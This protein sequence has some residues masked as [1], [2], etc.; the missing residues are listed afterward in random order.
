MTRHSEIMICDFDAGMELVT[1]SEIIPHEPREFPLHSGLVNLFRHALLPQSPPSVPLELPPGW[2][3]SVRSDRSSSFEALNSGMWHNRPP[4]ESRVKI[5]YSR[6][7]SFFD[8][9][10]SSLVEAR[11]GK[12]KDQFCLDNISEADSKY[13]RDQ[14]ADVFTR[15]GQGSGIDW[16]SI[17]QVIVD[18]YGKRLELLRYILENPKPKRDV[19]ER[20]AEARSQVLIMLTPYMLTSAIPPN[21]TGPVDR[22]WID[23]VVKH[24]ASTHTA[25]APE[26]LLTPQEKVI[27]GAVEEVLSQICSVLGDIWV[28]AFDS[29]KAGTK[30]LEQFLEKWQ[31]DIIGLVDW[32]EWSIWLKCDPP[33]GPEVSSRL[34]LLTGLFDLQSIVQEICYITTFPWGG[35]LFLKEGEA[36]DLTPRCVEAVEP[37]S[38]LKP[39]GPDRLFS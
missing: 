20:V 33:C 36:V 4:G 29:E 23:P 22:S 34:F 13:I 39:P 18:R 28:D 37:F 5:D 32:L 35:Y 3:G 9:E 25:W 2:R 11:A 19:T 21:P 38:F 1:K 8:T 12:S 14:L 24:C 27:K 16:G 15:D 6:V 10:L 26:A 31:S 30:E 17:T 7:V